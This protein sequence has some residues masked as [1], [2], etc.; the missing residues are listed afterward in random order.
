MNYLFTYNQPDLTALKRRLNGVLSQIG[1]RLDALFDGADDALLSACLEKKS[2]NVFV[3]GKKIEDLGFVDSFYEPLKGGVF[4]KEKLVYFT[5]KFTKEKETDLAESLRNFLGYTKTRC[6][7]KLYGNI[8][9]ELNSFC[10]T[11]LKNLTGISHF[12]T[13][14]NLDIKLEILLKPDYSSKALDVFLKKFLLKF[15]NYVYSTDDAA[16]PERLVDIL[17]IQRIVMSTAESMTGGNI[18]ATIVKVPGASEVFFEGLTTYNTLSKELRL[19]VSKRTILQNTVYSK[20][21][22]FEM[23]RALINENSNAGISITGLAPSLTP[24]KNDGLC[25]I[26]VAYEERTIV[27]RFIFTGDRRKVIETA[28]N[29]AIF[30]LIK[31]LTDSF[32]RGI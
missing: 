31:L 3:I 27:S 6:V 8:V 21:V 28:T 19:N 9:K 13:E 12:I 20:E 4:T 7:F 11:N 10:R 17:K 29:A 18:A 22:A 16:L 26:G 32:F 14:E 5:D 2:V 1:Q 24:N 23:V 15:K 30:S 25:Y